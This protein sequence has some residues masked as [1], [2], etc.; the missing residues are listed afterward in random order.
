MPNSKSIIAYFSREGN[1]Y[2]AGSVVN[3]AVGKTE[4]IAKKIQESTGSDLFRIK[5]VQIY[6]EGY[7]EAT[8]VAQAE[9]RENARPKLMDEVDNLGGY[10]TVFVGYPNW[11]RTTPMAV[12]SFLESSD[13]SGKTIVPFCTHEGSGMGNSER[14]IQKLCP[15]AKMLPGLAIK[16]SNVGNADKAIT[17]WLKNLGLIP[18]R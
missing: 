7:T 17:N 3:L 1:N 6:P 10:D 13:F 9:L 12:C 18:N 4:V 8:R 16:G 11:W 2:V 14:D 15:S 5:T